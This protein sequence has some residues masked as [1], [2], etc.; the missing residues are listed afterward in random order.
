MGNSVSHDFRVNTDYQLLYTKRTL[1]NTHSMFPFNLTC[2]GINFPVI[3]NKCMLPA[4]SHNFTGMLYWASDINSII[5]TALENN[6]PLN[7]FSILALKIMKTIIPNIDI[8]S[9]HIVYHWIL[10]VHSISCNSEKC[11]Y[12]VTAPISLIS[13]KT[14]LVTNDF[15]LVS[16]HIINKTTVVTNNEIIEV[17]N[18]K[19]STVLLLKRY[20]S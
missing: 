4:V 12:L 5:L 2:S 17:S 3:L 19:T 14:R 9:M 15:N 13:C 7:S 8:L 1:Y 6:C 16:L 10:Q 20:F 18:K 11:S